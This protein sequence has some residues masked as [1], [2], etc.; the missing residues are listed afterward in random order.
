LH[1]HA[2]EA[3]DPMFVVAD[4]LDRRHQELKLDALLLRVMNFL[5]APGFLCAS[6]ENGGSWSLGAV[7][8]GSARRDHGHVAPAHGGH[9]FADEAGVS[10]R[11]KW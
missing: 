1:A 8:L 4:H 6:A 10:A 9:A 7:A 5:G 3:G 11:G 2:L